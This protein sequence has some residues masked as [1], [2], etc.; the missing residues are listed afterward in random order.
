MHRAATRG[1]IAAAAAVTAVGLTASTVL[2]RTSPGSADNAWPY[3]PAAAAPVLAA[4]GDIACQP[5]AN[6]TGGEA[7]KPGSTCTVNNTSD[8][9]LRNQA[10]AATANQIESMQPSLVAILGDEQYQVGTYADFEGSFDKTYGAFKFLQRPAPGNHEFYGEHGEKGDDGVGY[11]DYYNGLQLDPQT[12]QPVTAADPFGNYVQPVPRGNGQAGASGQGWYSYNLGSWHIISLN[13]ECAVNDPAFKS[14]ANPPAW[15]AQET[16]WLSADLSADHAACTLVYW[17]QPAFSAS[18][19][20]ASASQP[21]PGSAEGTIAQQQWWPLLYRH[22][23]DVVLNGHEH[24]YARFAPMNPQGSVD[25]AHGIR[26]FTVGTG[27]EGLDSL[28]TD[29]AGNVAVPNL[30]AGQGA[31]TSFRDGQTTQNYPGAFGAMKM[32]LGP[33]G[34]TW[35]YQSAPAPATQA[36]SPAWGSFTDTGHAACHGPAGAAGA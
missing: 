29:S 30:Q 1:L 2:A 19:P 17:H 15:L 23:V 34:Y 33:D 35:D 4:V 25:Y 27:G 31:G 26:Q 28:Y 21:A 14:C 10:M 18:H 32:T 24:L 5:D 3:A 9:A 12:G 36:G 16:Q 22:G 11:F 20:P 8:A 7:G 13:V 6:N